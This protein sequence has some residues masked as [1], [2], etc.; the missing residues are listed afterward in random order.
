M[1]QLIDFKNK[2]IDEDIYIYASCKNCDFIDNL[3]FENKIVID[4][5]QSYRRLKPN[6]LVMKLFLF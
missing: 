6:Y 5:N 2:Y 4:V 3:F 1:K